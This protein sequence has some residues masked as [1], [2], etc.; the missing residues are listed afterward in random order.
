MKTAT[1]RSLRVSVVGWTFGRTVIVEKDRVLMEV[2]RTANDCHHC[3]TCRRRVS[4]IEQALNGSTYVWKWEFL[5][6]GGM[7]L[8]LSR[9]GGEDPVELLRRTTGLAI[10]A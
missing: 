7:W 8:S 1:P 5:P 6:Q 4:T 3:P 9:P 10:D 2:A